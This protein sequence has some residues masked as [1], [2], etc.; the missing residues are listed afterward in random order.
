M[1]GERVIAMLDRVVQGCE[2]Y[3]GKIAIG[4]ADR[5]IPA[6]T[7]TKATEKNFESSN[8]TTKWVHG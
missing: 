5:N 6:V 8:L 3:M 7:G 2:T 4:N 1:Y